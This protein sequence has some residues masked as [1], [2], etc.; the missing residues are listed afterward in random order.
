MKRPATIQRPGHDQK[1]ELHDTAECKHEDAVFGMNLGEQKRPT[2]QAAI[3][4]ATKLA[5]RVTTS[6]CGFG[7]PRASSSG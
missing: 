5:W 2:L 3:G 6:S 4:L 1:G 7:R